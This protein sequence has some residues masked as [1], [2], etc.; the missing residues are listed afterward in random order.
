M[1]W[2]RILPI[3]LIALFTLGVIYYFTSPRSHRDDT[4]ER[5]AESSEVRDEPGRTSPIHGSPTS[6]TN[7]IPLKDATVPEKPDGEWNPP[8]QQSIEDAKD[9]ERTF[10]KAI[11]H[12]NFEYAAQLVLRKKCKNLEAGPESD[13]CLPFLRE[14]LREEERLFQSD[15][16]AYFY[17]AVEN[18]E[19]LKKTA[20]EDIQRINPELYRTREPCLHWRGS[21]DG[22]SRTTHASACIRTLMK[23]NAV[24]EA[25]TA[26]WEEYM[27]LKETAPAR[28]EMFQTEMSTVL[29]KMKLGR[30]AN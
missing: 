12:G 10:P 2:S 20:I 29:P 4:R 24:G 15:E 9:F 27:H 7:E 28:A 1:K 3:T 25:E 19:G 21:T 30:A 18:D 17:V 16:L 8:V 14:K 11:S 6:P 23:L 26:F 22:E 13:D 5:L